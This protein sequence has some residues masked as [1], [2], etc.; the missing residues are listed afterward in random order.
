MSRPIPDNPP[1]SHAWCG[2]CAWKNDSERC[3]ALARAHGDAFQH[4]VHVFE[5]EPEG[6]T[7]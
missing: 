2:D 3:E 5:P 4:I 6:A 7:S 1:G